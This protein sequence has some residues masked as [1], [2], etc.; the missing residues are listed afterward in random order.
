M[1]NVNK[2]L[3]LTCFLLL[4]LSKINAQ[5]NTPL[6]VYDFELNQFP[7]PERVAFLEKLGY[8]GVTFHCNNPKDLSILDKYLDATKSS[9][10]TIP[11]VYTFYDFTE[12]DKNKDI[13]KTVTQRIKGKG[14]KLW[15][16]FNSKKKPNRSEVTKII[17]EISD[18]TAAEGVEFVI[19]PHDMTTIETVQQSVE[20]I[21]EAG[22]TNAFTSFH[23]CHELR[24]G[25]GKR[26]LEVV[27]KYASYIKL[28]S[29]SGADFQVP[30]VHSS[31]WKDTIKPLYMGDFDPQ[32]F[33]QALA[34]IGYT[35]P[36]VLHTYGIKEPAPEERLTKSLKKWH[37][38]NAN[39]SAIMK[40]DMTKNLDAPESCYFD[41]GSQAWY[42]TS[43]GGGG[44]PL[45][46]DGFGWISKLDRDGKILKSRWVEGLDAPTGMAAFGN[47][48]YVA[49]KGV[50]VE[51]DIPTAKIIRKIPLKGSEFVN[52]VAVAPNGDVYISDTFTDTIY[53]LPHKGEIEVFYTSKDLEY[54]NGLWVDGNSLIIATWG[55]MTNRATFETSRKGTLKKLNLKTKKLENIGAGAPIANFDSVVKYG[56]YYYGSEWVGGK[57]LRIDKKGRV[58]V[59]LT[60]YSQFADFGIDEEK[61]ILMMPEMSTN[62]VFTVDISKN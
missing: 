14:I 11:A 30:Y 47:T 1:K 20:L 32:D 55:P 28:A 3:I 36:M 7:I 49:D 40:T 19:Y 57:L 13:W 41:K 2:I 26:L 31:D 51:I 48:L 33:V 23:L 18:Y 53:R 29:I 39:V 58:K 59:I 8:S 46:K 25:N 24:A 54:P 38:I 4:N 22:A 5:N 17:K 50:L 21:K 6:Y 34:Q 56:D 42:V 35:A 15:V 62:R 44:V 45:D 52:D 60:G 43:L 61:G 37:E 12:G 10:F 16:I 9:K 27:R